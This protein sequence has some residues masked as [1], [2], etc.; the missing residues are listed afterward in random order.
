M[1]KI[2]IDNMADQHRDTMALSKEK[3]PVVPLGKQVVTVSVGAGA[4]IEE[5]MRSLGADVVVSGGQ[6]MNPSVEDFVD[7][8]H[9]GSAKKYIIMP[10]NKNIV[11]AALQAKKLLPEKVEVVETA[12]IPQG[13]AALMAY[14]GELSVQENLARMT[15]R[16]KEVKAGAITIAVRDSMLDGHKVPEGS[17]IGVINSHVAVYEDELYRALSSLVKY[18]ITPESEIVSLYYGCDLTEDAAEALADRLR[19]EL[20]GVEVE[21]YAG[22]QPLYHFMISVE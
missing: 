7:V 9:S 5:I 1:S 20:G 2:K 16:I 6:T 3:K 8:I 11:L 15:K 21:L 12:N 19:G 22:G 13:F 17:Y 18:L 4:G 14:D 10:N